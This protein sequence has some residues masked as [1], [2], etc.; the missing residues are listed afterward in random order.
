MQYIKSIKTYFVRYLRQF[1]TFEI[2]SCASIFII[3]KS[4][5]LSAFFSFMMEF[6]ARIK[7]SEVLFLLK[8]RQPII[9]VSPY[10]SFDLNR[11]WMNANPWKWNLCTVLSSAIYDLCNIIKI[12]WKKLWSSDLNPGQLGPEVGILSSGLFCPPPLLQPIV[13]VLCVTLNEACLLESA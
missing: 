11:C 4:I 3:Y 2:V 9:F 10:F 5:Y 12:I 1:F 8:F 7:K 13:C 6:L